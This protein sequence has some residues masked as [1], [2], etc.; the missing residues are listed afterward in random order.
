MQRQLDFAP[1]HLHWTIAD[2]SGVVWTDES[3]F[4]LG[5]PVTQKRV[6]RMTTQKF[7]LES[8]AVNHQSGR[9]SMMVWGAICGPIQSELIIIPLGQQRAIDFIENV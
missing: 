9:Q 7:D 6:W 3:S 2:W 5:E 4:E 1:A 8:M